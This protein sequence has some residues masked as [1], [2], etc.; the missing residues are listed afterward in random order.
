MK[1]RIALVTNTLL[2]HKYWIIEMCKHHN[3]CCIIH[4]LKSVKT[5]SSNRKW[6]FLKMKGIWFILLLALTKVYFLI[7]KRN[8]KIEFREESKKWFNYVNDDYNKI[9]KNLIYYVQTINSK[10][11]IDIIK[12]NGIDVICSLGGEIA[13]RE[14]IQSPKITCLNYHSGLSP[15]YNGS[16][17]YLWAMSERRPNFIGGT[18]MNMNEKVDGGS[19]ISQFLPEI[20]VHDNASSL[21]MKSIIGSV[22]LY[23]ITLN[24]LENKSFVH[25]LDQGRSIRYTRLIDWT[26]YQEIQLNSFY[27]SCKIKEYEREARVFEYSEKNAD[28]Y[29]LSEVLDFVLSTNRIKNEKKNI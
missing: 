25:G 9:D 12:N 6:T 10:E 15:F 18:L 17:S 4:P 27:K 28:R 5:K 22:Q 1:L 20:T 16:K 3:I 29:Y 21:F 14:F 23:K 26:F 7:S 8:S 11:A 19:I 13:K 24:K 2:H